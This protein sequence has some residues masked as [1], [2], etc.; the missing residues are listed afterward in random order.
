[1]AAFA[2]LSVINDVGTP[3]ITEIVSPLNE[4]GCIHGS[5]FGV[6]IVACVY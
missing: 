1:L 5:S 6:I 3:K 4:I 2:E